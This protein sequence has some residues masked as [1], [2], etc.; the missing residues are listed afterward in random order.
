MLQSRV[1]SEIEGIKREWSEREQLLL[2]DNET[3][4]ETNKL[5]AGK[6]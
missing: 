4:R 5:L 6:L 2:Q 1:V 3:L